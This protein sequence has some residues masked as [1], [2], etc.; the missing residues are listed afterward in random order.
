MFV[1]SHCTGLVK[2]RQGEK[3]KEGL[4]VC[5][6]ICMCSSK[7]QIIRLLTLCESSRSF[8]ICASSSVPRLPLAAI[9]FFISLRKTAGVNSSSFF[10]STFFRSICFFLS[11]ACNLCR[12]WRSFLDSAAFSG[13]ELA[14]GFFL[15]HLAR[16]VSCSRSSSLSLSKSSIRVRRNI[17]GGS[18]GLFSVGRSQEVGSGSFGTFFLSLRENRVYGSSLYYEL[19]GKIS[20]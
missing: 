6:C 2:A 18:C 4:C 7:M 15:S 10:F 3:E 5:V 19:L 13:F 20:M 12:S 14:D 16:P 11:S 1:F 17:L 9:I 8:F